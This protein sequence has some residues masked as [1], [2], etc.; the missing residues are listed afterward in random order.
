MDLQQLVRMILVRIKTT[1]IL[2]VWSDFF[3]LSYAIV[4]KKPNRL[5]RPSNIPAY[6][7]VVKKPNS[8][9]R[10]SNIPAYVPP[11]VSSP[12]IQ[13]SSIVNDPT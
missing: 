12:K 8:L 2:I 9:T 1:A 7:I 6:A 13:S 11:R 3:R 10:P 5:T 4:V